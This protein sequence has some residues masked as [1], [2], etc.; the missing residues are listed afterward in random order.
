MIKPRFIFGCWQD[1]DV[2]PPSLK[3]LESTQTKICNLLASPNFLKKVIDRVTGKQYVCF[4]QEKCQLPNYEKINLI[5]A[6]AIW[7]T[8][9]GYDEGFINVLL[10]SFT[11]DSEKIDPLMCLPPDYKKYLSEGKKNL[12]EANL[13]F[14]ELAIDESLSCIFP[15]TLL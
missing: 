14:Q 11:S 4:P 15:P 10:E 13:F 6:K 12:E 5:V 3:K 8:L 7:H 1:D 9:E 2:T